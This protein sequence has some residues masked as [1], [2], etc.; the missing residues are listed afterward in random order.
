MDE[1]EP[2]PWRGRKQVCRRTLVTDQS[3]KVTRR[4]Q[5]DLPQ[6]NTI[7]YHLKSVFLKI[8]FRMAESK[9][10]PI[11]MKSAASRE[12]RLQPR[13]P[14]AGTDVDLQPIEFNMIY[15]RRLV[16]V[17]ARIHDPKFGI[18]FHF[19][20]DVMAAQ[21]WLFRDCLPRCGSYL[22]AA[23]AR[24]KR[25]ERGQRECIRSRRHHAL[26][27]GRHLPPSSG[28]APSQRRRNQATPISRGASRR[29]APTATAPTA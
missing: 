4:W 2:T 18:H 29:P 22:T 3:S 14:S 8:S 24:C 6:C 1:V 10:A 19:D 7:K 9:A 5:E 25:G 16:K 11:A 17:C 26:H 13:F 15:L 27:A 20:C 12:N 28:C 21:L 23:N